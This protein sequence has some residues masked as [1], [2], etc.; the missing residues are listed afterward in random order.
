[1]SREFER[2]LASSEAVK[3]VLFVEDTEQMRDA[4]TREVVHSRIRMVR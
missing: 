4:D 3:Y 1:M 2:L